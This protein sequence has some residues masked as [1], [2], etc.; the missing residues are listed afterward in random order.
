MAKLLNSREAAELISINYFTV[1]HR[2]LDVW[3]DLPGRII[4]R[5]KWFTR[6]EVIAA[7]QRRIEAAEQRRATQSAQAA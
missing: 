3:P 7:A 4:N 2:T 5:Q 6:D 1:S